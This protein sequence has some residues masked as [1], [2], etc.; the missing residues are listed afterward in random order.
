MEDLITATQ[1][2][3]FIV[4]IKPVGIFFVLSAREFITPLLLDDL[5]IEIVLYLCV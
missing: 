2:L 5:L 4:E 3:T 1:P